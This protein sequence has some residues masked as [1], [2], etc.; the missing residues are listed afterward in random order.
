MTERAAASARR[1]TLDKVGILIGILTIVAVFGL[2]FAVLRP[3]RI[4]AGTGLSVFAALPAMQGAALA[5]L[6]TVG[7]LWAMTA[8]RPAW[9]LAAGCAG[10]ATL[11][12]AVGAAAT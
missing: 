2:S 6:W 8:S 3:N 9:R 4:A 11:A 10:L 1:V 7:A 12:Y 5:A